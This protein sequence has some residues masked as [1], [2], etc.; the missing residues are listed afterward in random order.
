MKKENDCSG[1]EEEEE[2][3]AE[4]RDEN[5][6]KEEEEKE[7]NEED[8]EDVRRTINKEVPTTA[9]L[10]MSAEGGTPQTNI[11]FRKRPSDDP[12]AFEHPLLRRD[13]GSNH[14]HLSVWPTRKQKPIDRSQIA[15]WRRPQATD[16]NRLQALR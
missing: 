4:K 1:V 8:D 13:R 16:Q 3:E 7:D 11:E 14:E 5:D 2:H 6:D 15:L 10:P 12:Y 9:P